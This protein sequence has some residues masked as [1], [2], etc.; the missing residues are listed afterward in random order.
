MGQKKKAIIIGAGPA[1]LTAAYQL[2][3]NTDYVPIILESSPYIGGISKTINYKGNRIDI[4][5]HRFFTKSEKVDRLWDEIMDPA[6]PLDP[7]KDRVR[8]DY[9][10][11]DKNKLTMEEAKK[12]FLTRSRISRI[13]Y[14][15]KF[16]D[17]PVTLSVKTLRDLGFVKTLKII[18][19]F[20]YIKI[21]PK[22]DDS[23]LENFYI[24]RFGLELYKTFFKSYTE[25]LWGMPPSQI[26]SEWGAQRVKGVSLSKVVTDSI[27]KMLSIKN[28]KNT[29][30]S[31]IEQF[32][33]PALGPGQLWETLADKITKMGGEILLNHTVCQVDLQDNKILSVGAEDT[34]GRVSK[35]EGDIFFSTMPVKDLVKALSPKL[36]N[37]LT[38]IADGLPYRD[39]ITVG[40][41]YSDLKIKNQTN[42]ETLNNNIPDNWLYI[43]EPDVQICRIQIFN[44]WSPFMVADQ[45]NTWLG[46]EYVCDEKDDFWK[47]SD[48]EIITRAKKELFETGIA[49][50]EKFLDGTVIRMKKTYPAYSG[51]YKDFGKLRKYLDTIENLYLIGRNGMHRYNNQDHSMLTAMVAVDNIKNGVKTRENIWQVNTEAEYHEEKK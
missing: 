25:K 32:K 10:D 43:H 21:L 12:R 33:Y 51:T 49:D 29:E 5:G 8:S 36:S 7:A 44:N 35:F 40:L 6:F 48:H 46:L 4:G 18:G 39:F 20:V 28:S 16:F 14:Q 34:E 3:K 2:L 17:Y 13:F 15:K 50:N 26:S 38:L 45:K 11:T 41:L 30:A 1:G 9:V 31:L 47:M 37:E 24:N 23:T 19:G 22:K 27:K 42:I